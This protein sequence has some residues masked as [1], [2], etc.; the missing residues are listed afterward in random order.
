[1]TNMPASVH[2]LLISASVLFGQ[3]LASSLYLIYFSTLILLTWILKMLVLFFRSGRLN[4]SPRIL[5]FR[6]E[7]DVPDQGIAGV[8]LLSYR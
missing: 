1:M 7:W 2:T 4:S 6:V 8:T 5:V 3:S